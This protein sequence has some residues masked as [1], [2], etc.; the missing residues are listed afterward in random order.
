MRYFSLILFSSI[1]IFSVDFAT[2]NTDNVILIYTLDWLNFSFLTARPVFVPV[3]F[4]IDNFMVFMW[5]KGEEGNEGKDTEE[6]K[7]FR[8]TKEEGVIDNFMWFGDWRGRKK[9][10]A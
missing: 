3:F 8:S 7:A 6:E 4:I 5:F 9:K 2:Q 1:L 10:L